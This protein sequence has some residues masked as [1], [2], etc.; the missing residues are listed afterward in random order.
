MKAIGTEFAKFLGVET[1]FLF[2]SIRY[3]ANRKGSVIT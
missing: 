3:Q 1:Q 2:Q